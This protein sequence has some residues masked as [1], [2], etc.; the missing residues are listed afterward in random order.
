[1]DIEAFCNNIDIFP[2]FCQ[3]CSFKH[4]DLGHILTEDLQ[5]VEV[6]SLRRILSNEPEYK[7]TK[8]LDFRKVKEHITTEL[9]D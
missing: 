2:C 8:P 5:I 6:N 9:D 3:Y 1:M 7:E 4:K